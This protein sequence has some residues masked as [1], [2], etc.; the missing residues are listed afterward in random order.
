MRTI[1]GLRTWDQ[2]NNQDWLTLLIGNGAS[3]NIWRDFSYSQLLQQAKLD[4]AALQLFADLGTVNFETVL[5]GLWHADRVLNALGRKRGDVTR[6]Y[7]HVRTQLVAAVRGVHVPWDQVPDSTLTQ[8]ATE[9]DGHDLAFTLNYDLLTYW[10]LMENT[11]STVIGDYFWAR[12]NIFDLA[13]SSRSSGR[14]GLLYLHGGVHLWRDSATGI[15]G[16]WTNQG[17]GN[18]LSRLTYNFLH[19]PNRQPLFVSEGSSAQKLRVI[20]RSDYLTFARQ[21]LIDDA[22]DTV[23]FGVGFGAQDEHIVRALRAGGRRRMAISIRPGTPDQVTAAA[24]RYREKLPNQNL[25]FFDY[26]TTSGMIGWVS[27]CNGVAAGS[28]GVGRWQLADVAPGSS[29]PCA[30]AGLATVYGSG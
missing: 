28:S 21:E 25:V 22:W 13:D 26:P 10:A 5:E 11:A 15:C 8:T 2:L 19:S 12:H 17:G 27:S 1:R 7:E 18:L 3:I 14:T 23:I 24:A 29:A 9:L 20:R 6:L 16:K 30:H 4:A